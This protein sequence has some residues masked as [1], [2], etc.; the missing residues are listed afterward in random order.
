MFASWRREP[1]WRSAH[2]SLLPQCCCEWYLG[3]ISAI[4]LTYQAH[5]QRVLLPMALHFFAQNLSWLF[6]QLL[7]R[8]L[9]KLCSYL[10]TRA[11]SRASR[12]CQADCT[13]A[14]VYLHRL[15]VSKHRVYVLLQKLCQI[16]GDLLAR[17]L[18]EHLSRTW[19]LKNQ[20]LS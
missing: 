16:N 11:R 3:W 4:L 17:T 5:W 2:L 6:L 19:E 12:Y 7:R 20:D 10:M 18:K 14:L 13:H 15:W 1:E 8:P 9:L